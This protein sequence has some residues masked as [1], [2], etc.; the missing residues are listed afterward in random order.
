[1]VR[2]KILKLNYK[3]IISL[4]L[5]C[6][7][8]FISIFAYSYAKSTE[9]KAIE[10]PILMYH[11]ILKSQSGDYIV[12]PDILERD[13]QYIQRNGYTT[14]TITDLVNYVYEDIALPEKPIII[15]FDDGHYNNLTYAV[16]LLEKYNMVAVISIVG[17]YTDTFS[18]S[19]E[20]NSNY[21]YLRWKDIELL[22]NERNNR[23]SKSYL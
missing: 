10:V 16:P 5:I 6:I 17:N 4:L 15:T 14:I 11:S 12:H 7:I 1:M 18:K 20:V 22:H 19:N 8:L 21:S 3:L 2:I 13:L 23:I 9:E